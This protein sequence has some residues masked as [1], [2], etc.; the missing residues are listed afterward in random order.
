MGAVVLLGEK[1]KSKISDL[2][3]FLPTFLSS[4]G[5]SHWLNPTGSQQRTDRCSPHGSD[6][7]VS[8]QSGEAWRVDLESQ[9]ENI[10]HRLLLQGLGIQLLLFILGFC[11]PWCNFVHVPPSHS[12]TFFL[13]YS[14]WPC[15]SLTF[16]LN[17]L[18]AF[19]WV[20]LP[21]SSGNM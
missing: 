6:F 11:W 18:S 15:F 5:A 8:E 7:S 21:K 20:L 13:S 9:M 19:G 17:W 4:A 14:L 16:L 2:T 12:L 10:P 1:Q 3:H